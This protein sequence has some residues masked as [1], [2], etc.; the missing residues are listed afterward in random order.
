M[1]MSRRLLLAASLALMSLAPVAHG[2][3]VLYTTSSTVG[4]T[5]WEAL[6]WVPGTG[7]PGD[8]AL[9]VANFNNTAALTVTLNG[10]RSLGS[11]G[12]TNTNSAT[13]NQTSPGD[14]ITLNSAGTGTT[15]GLSQAQILKAGSG[16]LVINAPIILGANATWANTNTSGSLNINGAVGDGAGS[17]SLTKLGNG[18]ILVATAAGNVTHEGGT[19]I[20]AGTLQYNRTDNTNFTFGAGSITL[21]GGTFKVGSGSTNSAGTMFTPLIVTANGGTLNPTRGDGL[22]VAGGILLQGAFT[23]F[24]GGGGGTPAWTVTAPVTLDQ[25]TVGL[26]RFTSNNTSN[27]VGRITANIVDDSDATPNISSYN[28]LSLVALGGRDLE[29]LG[30][31]NTYAGGTVIEVGVRTV[32]VGASSSLGT[33]DVLVKADADAA[34]DLS[35]LGNGNLAATSTL[36]I[37]NGSLVNLGFANTGLGIAE[38]SD[39]TIKFLIVNGVTMAPGLYNAGNSSAFLAGTGELNVLLPE[40]S[41]MA[42]LGLGLTALLRRRRD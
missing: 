16:S 38:A 40:P 20:K 22:S 19:V 34:A 8:D 31:G 4:P 10:S 35:L 9:D 39:L 6:T 27:G 30:G 15:A 7:T 3:P 42:L 23:L 11:I 5:N 2:A 37:E 24:S 26:R 13:I 1:P 41:S 18:T 28:A 14:T 32:I 21:D 17:F 29:I 12:R 33:G 36:S 25:N